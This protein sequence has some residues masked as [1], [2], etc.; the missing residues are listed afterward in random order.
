M[1]TPSDS[2]IHAPFQPGH[3]LHITCPPDAGLDRDEYDH[4]QYA[5]PSPRLAG[6]RSESRPSEHASHA[7]SESSMPSNSIDNLLAPPKMPG[8]L[9]EDSEDY[10]SSSSGEISEASSSDSVDTVRPQTAEPNQSLMSIQQ[11]SAG[12]P[13]ASDIHG[14]PR[15][16]LILSSS[17]SIQKELTYHE[18]GS[19]P[20]FIFPPTF[21]QVPRSAAI[22]QTS[23][24]G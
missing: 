13:A 23:V 17:R 18:D 20:H 16:S 14:L 22:R 7:E 3:S 19:Y 1:P 4:Y 15:V 2:V 10:L 6:Q 8:I 11:E 21:Q 24:P 9:P 5:G 12:L